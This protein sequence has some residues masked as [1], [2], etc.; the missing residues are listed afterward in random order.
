MPDC[1]LERSESFKVMELKHTKKSKN[2]KNQLSVTKSL[3][4]RKS[5]QNCNGMLN[6]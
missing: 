4:Y 2:N 1:D 3:H 5:N 6:E